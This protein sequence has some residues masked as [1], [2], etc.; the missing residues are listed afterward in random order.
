MSISVTLIWCSC[1]SKVTSLLPWA[2]CVL[3]LGF[4]V[5]LNFKTPS[6]TFSMQWRTCYRWWNLGSTM[7][8]VQATKAHFMVERCLGCSRRLC[9]HF[10]VSHKFC[11]CCRGLTVPW[12]WILKR[13]GFILWID[14]LSE[15]FILKQS[16]FL[17]SRWCR[18]HRDGEEVGLNNKHQ[19]H[20]SVAALWVEA[21]CISGHLDCAQLFWCC[22]L[23]FPFI[24]GY[25]WLIAKWVRPV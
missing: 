21:V 3:Q 1:L 6:V 11:P 24:L 25:K 16:L 15:G 14:P 13:P 7:C 12:I 2:M 22:C 8:H 10:P 17:L 20:S 19:L 4:I 18:L 5:Q 9:F 23:F